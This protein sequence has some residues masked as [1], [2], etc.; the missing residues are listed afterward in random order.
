MF[1][2]DKTPRVLTPEGRP[3]TAEDW[4]MSPVVVEAGAAVGSGAVIVAPVRIGA[5]ALVGAGAVVTRDV[6]PGAVVSGVPARQRTRPGAS[7][8]PG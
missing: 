2:N 4:T 3:Q 8:A 5:G 7:G 1:T 6:P